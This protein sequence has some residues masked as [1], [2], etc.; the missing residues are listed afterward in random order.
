MTAMLI[1]SPPTPPA[2][3]VPSHALANTTGGSTPVEK[4]SEWPSTSPNLPTFR[5]PCDLTDEE[6]VRE[7]EN[8]FRWSVA[9]LIRAGEVYAEL[10][11]R[12]VQVNIRGLMFQEFVPRIAA[13]TLSPVA[14]AKFADAPQLL[15][16]VSRLTIQEQE[17]LAC[18]EQVDVVPAAGQPVAKMTIREAH[19]ARY[20]HVLRAGRILTPEQQ[21]VQLRA[22]EKAPQKRKPSARLVEPPSESEIQELVWKLNEAI[23]TRGLKLVPSTF[24]QLAVKAGWG[25]LKR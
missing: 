19:V 12:D 7:F 17:L 25:P 16:S 15:Q 20:T 23:S 14:V 9:A 24:V 5:P 4:K 21:E 3:S 22:K 18:D 11:K 10:Q 8:I 13:G 6:L 2:V 1:D